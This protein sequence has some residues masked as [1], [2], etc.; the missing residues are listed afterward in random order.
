MSTLSLN[1]IFNRNFKRF[2]NLESNELVRMT[3]KEYSE[4]YPLSDE[5]YG[6]CFEM[7]LDRYNQN[8]LR[9]VNFENE[10]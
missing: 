3:L 2:K 1:S 4:K 9:L 7:L 8:K 10:N 6:N 5:G